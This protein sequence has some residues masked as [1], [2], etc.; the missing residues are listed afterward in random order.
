[1]NEHQV[2]VVG[3]INQDLLISTSVYPKLG[4][5]VHGNAVAHDAGGKGA[6]QAVAA[7]RLGASTRFVGCVGD[8]EFGPVMAN[9][10]RFHGVDTTHVDEVSGLNTGLAVVTRTDSG[11]NAIIV[12]EGA[13]GAVDEERVEAGLAELRTGDIVVLQLEIPTPSVIAA[14]AIAHRRGAMTIFNAAPAAPV[15]ELLPDVDLLVVNEFEAIT[16]AGL[17]EQP[18]QDYAAIARL[19]ADQYAVNVIITL[20]AEGSWLAAEGTVSKIDS[21]PVTPVDSTGAGDTFV[22]ALA[23]LLAQGYELERA[24]GLAS[25]AGAHACLKVGAQAGAPT[26]AELAA[27]FGITQ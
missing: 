15:A 8:D 23:S 24:A 5:T 6:N 4:E 21:Y 11:Q 13:N 26:K 19:L 27:A 17:P 1:M 25:A 12:I 22:G 7:A 10:L 9:N 16:V 20:G 3:S 2:Y 18:G 14:L